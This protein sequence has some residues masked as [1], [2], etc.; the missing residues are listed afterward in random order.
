MGIIGF[1]QKILSKFDV[2]IRGQMAVCEYAID[3]TD[4][5]TSRQFSPTDVAI[6]RYSRTESFLSLFGLKYDLIV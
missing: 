3:K 2:K 6:D 5:Y 4:R 1:S